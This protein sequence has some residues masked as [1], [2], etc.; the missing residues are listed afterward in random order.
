MSDENTQT[1]DES[2]SAIDAAVNAAKARKASKS[3]S[4]GS[5]TPKAAKPEKAAKPTDEEKAAAK[6]AKQV[7]RE[8]KKAEKLAGRKPAHMS[9]VE[10]AAKNLPG[11]TNRAE[12]TFNELI[13][14]LTAS[15]ITSLAAHLMH[16]N[17]AQATERSLTQKLS[18]GDRVRILGGD[19]KY[20]GLMGTLSKVQRIRTYVN[21]DGFTKPA[22]C[23]TADCEKIEA[24]QAIDQATG[25]DG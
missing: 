16:F 17:R 5:A 23:F 13:V 20:V 7:L 3:G 9:K 18:V 10:R 8:A 2:I 12:M 14:N 1:Q 15:E 4:G 6:A 19:P 11:L 25:T 21:V 22:Y 24:E